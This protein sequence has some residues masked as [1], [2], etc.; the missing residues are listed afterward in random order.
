MFNIGKLRGDSV[1]YYVGGVAHTAADYYFGRGEAAGR[2]TGSLAPEL[3]LAGSVEVVSATAGARLAGE[4]GYTL[5]L[6]D[7]AIA[8]LPEGLAAAL[9]DQGR[10]VTGL[11][12]RGVTRLAAGRKVG[13]QVSLLPLADL[14][15]PVLP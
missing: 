10:I 3:G 2:W 8:Q 1:D 14:G 13:G 15:I 7:G 4:G 12:D 6:V 9:D 11:A 5:V